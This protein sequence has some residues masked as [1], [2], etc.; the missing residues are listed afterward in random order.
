MC[1]IFTV[2]TNET[3]AKDD[4]V[5]SKWKKS[6]QKG[7]MRGPEHSVY[8]SLNNNV[9]FG[10]H[11]LAIN[12]LDDI[13]NQPI[14]INNVTLIC[15]GEIYNYKELYKEFKYNATTNSDCEI[16]IH[17]YNTFGIES[18][19]KK[20]DGVF[21]F[22]LLDS[23]KN[24][25]YTGRDPF[26]VR[27]MYILEDDN[28]FA[29]GSELKVLH[30]LGGNIKHFIPGTYSCFSF[31]DSKWIQMNENVPYYDL[32]VRY[33]D[34]TLINYSKKKD[35]LEDL[36]T[37]I[38]NN[39]IASVKKRVTT[40]DR[41]IAC[42]LS[43]GLDSSLICSL[44]QREVNMLYPDKKIETYSIGFE[45]SDDLYY[46]Q[47][48]ADYIGTKHTSVV[49]DELTFLNAIPDVVKAVETY[50]TTTIR[51]SVGNYLVAK[52][53]SEN[54]EAKVIFNGDGADELM[55]GYMYFHACPDNDE[56]DKECKRLL[57]NMHN[58]D[59]LRSDKSISSWGLEARTPLLDKSWVRFYLSLPIQ[60]RNHN[61]ENNIEKYLIRKAFSY[62]LFFENKDIKK[63]LPDEVLWRKK[64]AFSDGVSKQT[65]SWY[66]IIQESVDL[67][68]DLECVQLPIHLNTCGQPITLEQRYYYML[69]NDNYPKRAP[70]L[71]YYWMPR[72][73]ESYDSSARTLDIYNKP[74]PKNITF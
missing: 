15:N 70:I 41:P 73:V 32:N 42:L 44:V 25:V 71:K 39:L 47:K 31:T 69:F 37:N 64:E 29:F 27:P 53:I 14:V 3:I 61:L 66:Q 4:L 24:M 40:T 6:F 1:G 54:S 48:V 8:K 49:V 57:T 56:F 22:V 36:Y 68:D 23:S 20:L 38:R 2:L 10:F 12:G 58:Y 45:G 13:S 18:T 17:L 26:G 72:Y 65:R 63:A 33:L 19:I 67:I 62:P 11:R 59:V 35:E 34:N 9:V 55:G 28:K 7:F 51:A 43:G 52:Y 30:D 60:L 16:I 5:H 46:A 74:M 50:D 21:A